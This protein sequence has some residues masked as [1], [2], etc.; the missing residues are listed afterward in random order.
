M[1]TVLDWCAERR[2]DSGHT[3]RLRR[4]QA[5]LPNTRLRAG[6]GNEVAP[7]MRVM[8]VMSVPGIH[9]DHASRIRNRAAHV[10]KLHRRVVDVETVAEH[11]LDPMEDVVAQ[12]RRHILDQHVAAQRVRVRPQAPDM[13][14]VHAEHAFDFADRATTCLNSRPRGSPSSR[15]LSDSR[16]ISH[17][18][19]MIRSEMRTESRG[20]IAS[21]LSRG[22]PALPRQSRRRRADRPACGRK[23][24]AR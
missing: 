21:S 19:Q 8:M 17:A 9:G 5:A 23:P 15:M 11:V 13:E 22:S 1:I 10:L 3:H 6:F 20:S 24:R 14:I 2:I 16:V 18:V 7:L 12:R 4:W